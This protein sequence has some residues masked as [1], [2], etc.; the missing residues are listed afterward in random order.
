MDI[1][2]LIGIGI[3]GVICVLILK[4][5]KSEMAI[6]VSIGAG[7]IM[8]IY[9]LTSLSNVVEI[10]SNIINKT[11]IDNSLFSG[12]L[13]VIGIGYITEYSSSICKEEGCESIGSKIMLGGKIAIFMVSLPVL[14]SLVDLVIKLLP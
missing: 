6:F 10:F 12:V 4:N 1:Y 14:E 13:K 5:T 8:L 11:S 2:K 9:I 3:I 7:I